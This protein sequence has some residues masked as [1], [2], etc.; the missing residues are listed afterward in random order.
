MSQP[1]NAIVIT[2]I[3]MRTAV[4]NSSAQTCTSVRAGLN[5]FAVWPFFATASDDEGESGVVGAAVTPSLGDEPW[6]AKAIELLM[7]PVHEAL[8]QAGLSELDSLERR[9]LAPSV[10]LATPALPADPTAAESV[11]KEYQSFLEETHGYLSEAVHSRTLLGFPAA[12]AGGF[13][14][15]AHA[16]ADLRSGQA[17]IALVCGVDSLLDSGLLDTLFQ[18]GSLKT[19]KMSAGLIP[20]EAA[21]CLVLEPLAHAEAR[22]V[23]PLARLGA[24]GLDRDPSPLGAD[25]AVT[26]D[27]LTRAFRE[28]VDGSGGG[29]GFGEVV[30]DL[31]GERSRFLEWATVETRCL[32]GFPRGWKLS[33]P[34]DCW[35]D[36]GAAFGPLAA[37]L[38]ARSFQRGQNQAGVAV[39]CSAPSGERAVAAFF[40][41]PSSRGN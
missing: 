24:I 36:V 8:W 40:P 38:V 4:G 1:G 5:R 11:R 33:H 34:A 6:T 28:A 17:A 27:A 9:G 22:G 12:H 29:A 18:N 32:H 10:Y 15:L 35:G 26:G 37:G 30:V 2:G 21:A 23:R 7:E 3:G 39:C 25:A 19:E 16:A 13:A 41:V 14:A 31:T 20:G